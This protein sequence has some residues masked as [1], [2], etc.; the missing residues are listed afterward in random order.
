MGEARESKW[1]SEE[2]ETQAHDVS[3]S[4]SQDRGGTAG[5]VGEGEADA[6]EGR[7]ESSLNP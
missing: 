2:H 4:A 5:K 1:S 3:G 6:V 7:Q